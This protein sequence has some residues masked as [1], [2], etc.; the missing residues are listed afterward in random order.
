MLDLCAS[1]VDN[2]VEIAVRLATDALHAATIRQRICN[3]RPQLFDQEQAVA[4][5]WGDFLERAICI[6]TS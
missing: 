3:A 5:E 2:Y 1:S 4:N 6:N